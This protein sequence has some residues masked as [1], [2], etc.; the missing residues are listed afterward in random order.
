M[1]LNMQYYVNRGR[2]K[3]QMEPGLDRLFGHDHQDQ[4][5]TRYSSHWTCRET[6]VNPVHTLKSRPVAESEER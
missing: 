3:G 4:R 6:C 2:W 5:S 1:L